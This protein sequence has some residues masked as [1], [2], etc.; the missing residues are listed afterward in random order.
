MKTQTIFILE[1]EE[2]GND[3]NAI[4]SQPGVEFVDMKVV[5]KHEDGAEP[6]CRGGIW[7]IIRQEMGSKDL[8]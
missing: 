2:L 7:L 4:L 8:V 6:Y 5:E 1:T 3:I